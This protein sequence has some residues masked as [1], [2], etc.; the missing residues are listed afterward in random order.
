MKYFK[1]DDA[2]INEALFRITNDRSSIFTVRDYMRAFSLGRDAAQKAIDRNAK[3]NQISKERAKELGVK[4]PARANG[5]VFN[6]N[7]EYLTL[8]QISV[9]YSIPASTL[10]KWRQ[11]NKMESEVMLMTVNGYSSSLI[12]NGPSV[13]VWQMTNSNRPKPINVEYWSFNLNEYQDQYFIDEAKELYEESRNRLEKFYTALRNIY[14]YQNITKAGVLRQV[15]L[16]FVPDFGHHVIPSDNPVLLLNEEAAEISGVQYRTM[17]VVNVGSDGLVHFI[18]FPEFVRR[19]KQF[20]YSEEGVLGSDSDSTRNL[21]SDHRLNPGVITAVVEMAA[22]GRANATHLT[23]TLHAKKH[24]HPL[25]VLLNSSRPISMTSCFFD[26]IKL[27]LNHFSLTTPEMWLPMVKKYSSGVRLEDIGKIANVFGMHIHV[28]GNPINLEENLIG[29]FGPE[30]EHSNYIHTFKVY[31]EETPEPHYSALMGKRDSVYPCEKCCHYFHTKKEQERHPCKQSLNKNHGK[32]NAKKVL[33]YYD[34]ETVNAVDENELIP[35]SVSFKWSDR[36]DMTTYVESCFETK[37]INRFLEDVS[38]RA[39]EEDLNITLVA[40]N[41]SSFDVWVILKSLKNYVKITSRSIIQ[42]NSFYAL[43][44]VFKNNSTSTFAIWDP[45]LY[46]RSSLNDTATSFGIPIQKCDFDHVEIQK[47]YIKHKGFSFIKG[48][49]QKK[50]VE[51]NERDVEILE[52]I[53]D[54]M[55]QDI[56]NC[57]SKITASSYAYSQWKS[58]EKPSIVPPKTKED[59]EF[60][61]SAVVGGRVQCLKPFSKLEGDFVMIDVVSL[62]PSQMIN[63]L[64]PV[65]EGEKVI[66]EQPGLL[67]IYECDIVHQ[68]GDKPCVVPLRVTPLNWNYRGPQ[69]VTLSSVTIE[70][71][72]KTFGNDCVVVKHGIVWRESSS[73]V[74]T[75][76]ITFWKGVKQQQDEIKNTGE[77]NPV[78]RQLA[79]LMLNSL[80]GKTTQKVITSQTVVSTSPEMSRVFKKDFEDYK[81]EKIMEGLEIMTGDLKNVKYEYCKPQQLGVFVLDYAKKK[82]YEEIYSKCVVYYSDTD[83]ALISREDYE[84]LLN[85]Q[86]IR[87]GK[88]F[89][90]YDLELSD[91]KTCYTISPKCYALV[92][93][94]GEVKM[95]LKGV[96]IKTSCWSNDGVMKE[97][98]DIDCFKQ[99]I[100]DRSKVRFYCSQLVHN[101]GKLS[102]FFRDIIKNIN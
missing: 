18:D 25:Y 45:F 64:F 41:G 53:V 31:L 83:S 94:N 32:T 82:M 49:L 7:G 62:Y 92:M 85:N 15:T 3:I 35:Y 87:M 97:K 12:T 88:E 47:L 52:K 51:Y 101:K 28:I 95:R 22:I 38:Q 20:A 90:E 11:S 26:A 21:L 42:N 66:G 13:S 74:F 70:L 34:I 37:P 96:S 67:G 39:T 58:T 72:R 99:L 9:K 80:Y 77:Y 93:G 23:K 30:L 79:K 29:V 5:E 69:T 8:N 46:F 71:L 54:K 98:I 78:L 4:P 65:G 73:D 61:R 63:N 48:E 100:E 6:I 43:N 84:K 27:L 60:I 55:Q 68:N 76:F 81:F 33:L 1:T 16:Q 75:K 89:G 86:D 36:N 57:L 14:N 10:R 2:F 91:I 17:K 102:I 24:K 19:L 50:I 44:G 40:F 59:Y 56:P